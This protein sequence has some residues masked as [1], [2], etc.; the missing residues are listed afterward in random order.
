MAAFR[1]LI[2]DDHEWVRRSMRMLLASH[3]GWEVCGE[4]VDGRDALK[5]ARR[6]NPD[7]VLLDIGM[8]YLSGL[9]VARE[10]LLNGSESKILM[11]TVNSNRHVAQ[12]SKDLGAHGFLS[13]VDAVRDLLPA[14][15]TLQRGEKFF[16]ELELE[17]AFQTAGA[18]GSRTSGLSLVRSAQ[19]P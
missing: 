9:E 19:K 1:I 11:I 15:G 17:A 14:I 4:A 5:K 12:E 8:P 2:A 16:P 7:L 3:P 18:S 13:K 6:L 10:L